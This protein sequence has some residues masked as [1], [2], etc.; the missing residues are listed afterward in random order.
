MTDRSPARTPDP[1]YVTY[2]S[3]AYATV[4]ATEVEES[5]AAWLETQAQMPFIQEVSRR[6]F[7]LMDLRPGQSVL[8]VGC[9]TGVMLPALAEAVG[10]AGSVTGLDHA[11]AFLARAHQRLREAGLDERVRLVQGDAMALPFADGTFDVTHSERVLMHLPEADAAI[12]EMARVT[13]PGGRV[14]CAEVDTRAVE[15]DQPDRELFEQLL[16]V[17]ASQIRNPQIGIELRRRLLEAGLDPVTAVAIGDVEIRMDDEEI[18]EFRRQGRELAAQ[19]VVGHDRVETAIDHLV[20]TNE[21]GT[22]TGLA[23]MFIAAGTVLG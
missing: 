12:R 15:F 11:E 17:T 4:S 13:R 1:A 16:Q 6:T 23:V 7:E 14:V 3:D 19:G 2:T 20:R 22:Y 8:D 9:G 21:A 5:T 10:A 18:D